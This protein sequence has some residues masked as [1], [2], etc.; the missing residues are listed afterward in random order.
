M[1][2]ILFG[3]PGNHAIDESG[4]EFSFELTFAI[5]FCALLANVILIV[6][7]KYGDMEITHNTRRPYMLSMYLILLS[8]FEVTIYLLIVNV[9]FQDDYYSF[10]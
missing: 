1:P 8:L 10:T 5:L 2:I 7:L 6:R 4:R 9:F 3:G